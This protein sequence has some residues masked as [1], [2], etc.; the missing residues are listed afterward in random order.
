MRSQH[1]GN[2][3]VICSVPVFVKLHIFFK[4]LIVFVIFVAHQAPGQAG[5]D[6]CFLGSLC[7]FIHKEIH[8]GVSGSTALQHFQNAQLGAYIA[9]AFL[10]ACF[11]RP[12]FVL[13]PVHQRHV[14]GVTAQ[15]AHG[16]V[17]VGVH[18]TGSR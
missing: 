14:V 2:Q 3:S 1:D 5:T 12:Y 16:D 7:R 17:G 11:C 4:T 15:Q 10:Q 9:V 8:I 6:S 13:K 18:H